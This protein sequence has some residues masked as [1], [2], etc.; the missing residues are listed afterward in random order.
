MTRP[1][2]RAQLRRRYLEQ[3]SVGALLVAAVAL[4]LSFGMIP[5][6]TGYI[7]TAS[8]FGVVVGAFVVAAALPALRPASRVDCPRC[9]RRHQLLRNHAWLHCGCRSFVVLGAQGPIAV[10]P[11]A[12]AHYPVADPA[13]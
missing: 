2:T 6:T 7:L 5:A 9:G 11:L 3:V 1:H 10:M 12:P 13:S 4:F 8:T